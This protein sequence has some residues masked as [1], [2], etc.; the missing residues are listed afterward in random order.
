MR[1]V[2]LTTL[3]LILAGYLAVGT[4]LGYKAYRGPAAYST[5][6]F[7]VHGRH[8]STRTLVVDA[9]DSL[10]QGTFSA[11]Y[12]G[13]LRRHLNSTGFEF[14]NAGVN[15]EK[16][17]GLLKR[18][19]EILSCRPDAI[20]ITI[21]TN[22]L[23]AYLDSQTQHSPVS[24]SDSIARFRRDLES[25]IPALRSVSTPRIAVFS[26]PPIGQDMLSPAN[27]AVEQYN[28][29][30]RQV[31]EQNEVTYLPL[32]EQARE[33]I[34]GLAD[35]YRSSAGPSRDLSRNVVIRR[36]FL[37]QTWDQI[38]EKNGFAIHTDAIHLNSRGARLIADLEER[39]LTKGLQP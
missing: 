6:D 4:F 5:K 18:T 2:M 10:T 7:L 24:L 19:R 3:V 8:R 21:G 39:W 23:H 28:E 37:W 38:S 36:F 17:A 30:I 29:T 34:V 16:L 32:N 22:D 33:R 15:G 27:R 14:V 25:L 12:V 26:I 13:L 11:D 20:T 31:C 35:G 9:G 1:I